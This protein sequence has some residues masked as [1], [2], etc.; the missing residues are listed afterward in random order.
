MRSPQFNDLFVLELANNH[1]GKLDRGLKIIEAFGRVV[2]SNGVKA[3]IKL[4]FRDLDSFVHR[5]HRHREDHRYIKKILATQMSWEHLRS[6]V[7]A[8]RA[9]DMTTMVTPFDEVSVDRCVEFNVE[10][11]KVASS[12]IR[13]RFLIEKIAS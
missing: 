4:Q 11:L 10:F 2:R 13:D 6:L 9:A 7:E 5:D 12:D 8:I 1:L 3:A